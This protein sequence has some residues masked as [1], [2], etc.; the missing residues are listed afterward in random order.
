MPQTGWGLFNTASGQALRYFFNLTVVWGRSR[1]EIG[2]F[3]DVGQGGAV[4]PML[5]AYHYTARG[6]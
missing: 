3:D 6:H 5:C 4:S 1:E 2:P